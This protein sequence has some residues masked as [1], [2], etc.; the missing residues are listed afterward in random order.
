[1]SESCP[2]CG[3]ALGRDCWNPGECAMITADMA[4]QQHLQGYTYSQDVI[5]RL[6]ER[7]ESYRQSGQSAAHTADLLDEAAGCLSALLGDLHA[8]RETMRVI[9]EEPINSGS[10]LVNAERSEGRNKLKSPAAS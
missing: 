9:S 5:T 7:A 8:Y 10:G 4:S 2:S 6:H 1:M 3:G